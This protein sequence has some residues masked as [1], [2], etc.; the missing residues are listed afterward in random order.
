ML[1]TTDRLFLEFYAGGNIVLTDKDLGIISLLRIVS[2]EQEHLRVGLKYSLENRQNYNGVPDL[3]SERISAG[4]RKAVEKADGE[5]T[6]HQKKK[7]REKP[8]DAL[9]KALANSLSEYPP[10]LIDRTYSRSSFFLYWM[11]S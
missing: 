7:S 8:G 9:R 11:Q 10:M 2:E 4:L 3:T 5:L 6:A 1:A